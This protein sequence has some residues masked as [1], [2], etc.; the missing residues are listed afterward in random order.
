ML[1]ET[2][3]TAEADDQAAIVSQMASVPPAVCRFAMLMGTAVP[4]G[5][6]AIVA[7]ATQRTEAERV[8]I[9]AWVAV[10]VVGTAAVVSSARIILLSG[11]RVARPTMSGD[12]E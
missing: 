10:A 5:L 9:A 8:G 12:D 2:N 6:G 4:I 7:V 3:S 1:T 11:P